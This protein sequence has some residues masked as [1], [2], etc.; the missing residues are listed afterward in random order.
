MVRLNTNNW[1]KMKEI[2]NTCWYNHKRR[3]Y[4]VLE[5]NKKM[6]TGILFDQRKNVELK[7]GKFVWY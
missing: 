5:Y 2:G 3:T 6:K 4:I 7:R 1:R